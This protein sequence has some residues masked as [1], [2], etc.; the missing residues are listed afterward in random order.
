MK[1]YSLSPALIV[2][3]LIVTALAGCTS[4]PAMHHDKSKSSMPMSM[5]D[6]GHM[7]MANCD[8]NMKEM[9]P[10]MQQQHMEMMRQ[11]HPEMMRQHHPEMMKEKT[12]P[13]PMS[14]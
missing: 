6:K 13:Q 1:S 12:A 2:S 5:S 10:E 7:N 11:H 8:M 3:A 9:S 14:K 4:T